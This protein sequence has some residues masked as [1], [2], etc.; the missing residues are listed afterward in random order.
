[1]ADKKSILTYSKA[2]LIIILSN[3]AVFFFIKYIDIGAKIYPNIVCYTGNIFSGKIWTIISSGFV[4]ADINHLAFNM[5]AVF[6]FAHIVEEKFGCFRT[7]FIYLCSLII[8]MFFSIFVYTVIMQKNVVLIGASGAVMGLISTAMLLGPFKI[9]WE[10]IIPIPVFLK[11][12][13]FLYAD[14]KGFL[15]GEKDGV[16]HLAHLCGFFSIAV[17]VYLLDKKE[18]TL[19]RQGVIVNIC[20]LVALI[21]FNQWLEVRTGTGLIEMVGKIRP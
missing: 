10:T 15:G 8:S 7:L 14:V 9:T 18:Q 17:I 2:S 13:F 11:A 4:H 20:T 6:V 21:L 12:W 3:I 1:M 5:L 19:L 16:S